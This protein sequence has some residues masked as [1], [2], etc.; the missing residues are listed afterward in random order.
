MGMTTNENKINHDTGR[1]ELTGLLPSPELTR[2]LQG[3]EN[4]GLDAG[5]E[6]QLAQAVADLT[7]LPFALR[8]YMA[9]NPEVADTLRLYI[10]LS[11]ISDAALSPS[12][13]VADEESWQP[14]KRA[15]QHIHGLAVAR[16]RRLRRRYLAAA[17][18]ACLVVVA[19]V[20]ALTNTSTMMTLPTL[21]AANLDTE[22]RDEDKKV[23]VTGYDLDLDGYT[24]VVHVGNIVENGDNPEYWDYT[25]P[26]HPFKI[27]NHNFKF[28][29]YKRLE[30]Y[31]D[32][33]PSHKVFRRDDPTEPPMATPSNASHR[34]APADKSPVM[35]K[36]DVR[37][38]LMEFVDV[39]SEIGSENTKT[40]HDKDLNLTDDLHNIVNDAIGN[41]ESI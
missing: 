12:A 21:L 38:C 1:Q 15:L 22:N 4:A 3:W 20:Y 19:G 35:S 29:N 9:A 32:D 23:I 2:L 40:I 27:E 24:G 26:Q 25:D 6:E 28:S 18:V 13:T 36:D 5:Q 11:E 16:S 8:E 34:S 14:E 30:Y 41:I 10:E 33:P 7:L 37:N 17:A 31:P 39:C